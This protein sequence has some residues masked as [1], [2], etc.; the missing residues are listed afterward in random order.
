MNVSHKLITQL[1]DS[2]EIYFKLEEKLG[3]MGAVLSRKSENNRVQKLHLMRHLM[4]HIGVIYNL[5]G[6]FKNTE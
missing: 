2:S 4:S 3:I 6:I 1:N 5:E